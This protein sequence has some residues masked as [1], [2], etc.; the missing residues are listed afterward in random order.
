MAGMGSTE[1][2]GGNRGRE[3]RDRGVLWEAIALAGCGALVF[4]VG[5]WVA[6]G[7]VAAQLLQVIGAAA[8]L[9]APLVWRTEGDLVMGLREIRIPL[10]S[11]RARA[12]LAAAHAPVENLDALIA[13]A[14]APHEALKG[15]LPYLSEDVAS[16]QLSVPAAYE[17]LSL[18]DPAL[19]F[20]RQQLELSVI[21]LRR[22]G[23]E[24]W[25]AGGPISTAPWSAGMEILICGPSSSI[26]AARE[27]FAASAE[28]P[29][30]PS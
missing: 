18:V 5:R 15:I 11:R 10:G 14:H 13:V 30:G 12:A 25:T 27:R 21:A 4:V 3:P 26:E 29:R 22:A 24:R 7:D 9:V 19:A 28:S 20:L 1:E 2:R 23:E 17:G 16:A 6:V 8:A